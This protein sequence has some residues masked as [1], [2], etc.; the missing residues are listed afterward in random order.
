MYQLIVNIELIGVF[1]VI[2]IHGCVTV[3]ALILMMRMMTCSL[4]NRQTSDLSN[5]SSKS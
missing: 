1:H 5:S 3:S 2:V 4:S